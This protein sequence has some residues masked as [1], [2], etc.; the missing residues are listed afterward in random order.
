MYNE[1]MPQLTKQQIERQDFVDNQIFE[2]MQKLLPSSKQIEWDIEAIG[3]IRD[4]VRRQIVNKQ[5]L[6][7]A[8]KFYP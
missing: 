5:K 3:A 7:S 1:R 6:M 8:A 4:T 2:L